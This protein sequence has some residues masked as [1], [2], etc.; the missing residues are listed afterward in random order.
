VKSA[1]AVALYFTGRSGEVSD[2]VS[3][4][5]LLD[6]RERP[7]ELPINF[8]RDLGA[9]IAARVIAI[10]R[11]L[12]DRE[13]SF[14][15][16]YAVRFANQIAPL[17]SHP[18]PNWT[19]DAQGAVFWASGVASLLVGWEQGDA[20]RL[21]AAVTAFRAALTA[22]IRER[23]PLD[24]A[25]TQNSLGIALSRLGERESGTARL[26]EAVAAYRD[27]LKE[28]TR[29]RVPLQWAMTQNNLGAALSR[30]GERESGTAR[31]EEAVAAYRDALK[32][33]TRERAP[34]QWETT[35]KNLEN[36]EKMLAKR[37]HKN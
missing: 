10:G 28:Y 15:T 3:P 7:L 17:V 20:H 9:A 25:R 35:Q 6:N 37:R 1:N 16:P 13:G 26:E 30:L 29:E 34:L 31:L 14:L 21:E 12:V 18:K 23:V 32:E 4:Y 19:T 24:W 11:A 36:V 8:D 22:Y 5:T 27:A 33:Y 2:L